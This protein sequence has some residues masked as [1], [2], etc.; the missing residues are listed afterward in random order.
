MVTAGVTIPSLHLST[1]ASALPRSVKWLP[2]AAEKF[3]AKLGFALK[4][5]AAEEAP[6]RKLRVQHPDSTRPLP[7]L[8]LAGSIRVFPPGGGAGVAQGGLT[9]RAGFESY[10]DV[11]TTTHYARYVQ[12]GTKPHV[13]QNRRAKALCFYVPVRWAYAKRV[14]HP[15]TPANNFMEKGWARITEN[16]K[17][18]LWR[19]SQTQ[20]GAKFDGG[21]GAA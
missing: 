4:R 1:D 15:G 10:S 21:G 7:T 19:V 12:E 16:E 13:I 14:N 3:V 6:V 20:A 11:G 18:R 5:E 17:K 8:T 2:E 9:H